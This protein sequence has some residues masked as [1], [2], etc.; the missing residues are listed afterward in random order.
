[1]A[2]TWAIPAQAAPGNVTAHQ[3]SE[4]WGQLRDSDLVLATTLYRL[5]SSNVALCTDIVPETGLVLIS[6]DAFPAQ[7]RGDF[8]K[9]YGISG[10]I[11]VEAT[12]PD[13]PA[14]RAGVIPGSAI[15]AIDATAL[16]PPRTAPTAS[17][18]SLL[19]ARHALEQAKPD[20]PVT[21]DLREANVAVKRTLVPRPGCR[22]YADLLT[23]DAMTIQSDD[24]TIAISATFLRDFSA[25]ALPVLI[26]HELAHV[27]RHHGQRLDAQHVHRGWLS[28]FGHDAN[29]IR[30]IEDEADRVSVHLLAN[31]GYDPET[32]VAFWK[33]EGRRIYPPLLHSPTHGSPSERAA[34]IQAEITRMACHPGGCDRGDAPFIPSA[35]SPQP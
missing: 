18:A 31:A 29:M 5:T 4:V 23:D 10:A 13:S 19:F 22:A 2:V 16:P 30:A 35:T 27:I 12:I 1:M 17:T 20:Q 9:A 32:A 15:E 28:E 25:D 3:D 14:T 26:A 11:A 33:S 7:W 24:T 34:L 6:P 21:L 8:H